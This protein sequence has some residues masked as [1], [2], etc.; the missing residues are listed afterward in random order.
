MN[1]RPTADGL[2]EAVQVYLRDEV[3]RGDMAPANHHAP[4]DS[5]HAFTQPPPC[6]EG[7]S[8]VW[9]EPEGRRRAAGMH[10]DAV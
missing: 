1:E 10:Q 5:P 3:A 2:L 4:C 7:S 8:R 6:G 9:S